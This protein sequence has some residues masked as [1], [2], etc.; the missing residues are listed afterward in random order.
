MGSVSHFPKKP[1]NLVFLVNG[2]MNRNEYK[3]S[4]CAE[5]ENMP[6]PV[7]EVQAGALVHDPP[8]RRCAALMGIRSD[9]SVFPMEEEI[10]VEL[11]ENSWKRE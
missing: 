8:A 11:I 4:P 1:G 3:K 7:R 5:E 10:V 9:L 2:N 6:M